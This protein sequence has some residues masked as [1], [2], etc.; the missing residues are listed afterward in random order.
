M[1]LLEPAPATAIDDQKLFQHRQSAHCES[2]VVSNLLTHHGVAM[3]EPMAFGLSSS[4]TFAY[5]PFLKMAGMPMIAYRMM[6]GSIIR[7]VEKRLKMKWERRQ[8]SNPAEGKA[9][10][11]RKIDEGR[12]VGLQTCVY[13]LPYFPEDMRFHFNMHNLVAFAREGDEYIISDPVFEDVRRCD[14]ASLEKARFAKGELEAK[15]MMYEP[16]QIPSEIDYAE[17]IPK[18]IRWNSKTMKAPVPIAGIKGIRFLGQNIRKLAKSNQRDKFLPLYLG[19]IVRMQEEIGTGGGGFRFIYASFL[20]ESSKLLN[21]AV[22]R[23]AATAMT[24][25]GD[26]WRRFALHATKMCRGRAK[27]D[28][29]ELDAIINRCAD[30]EQYAWKVMEAV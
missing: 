24:D 29:D 4:L 16:T 14:S 23:E 13:W 22:L 25:A 11:D 8:F 20:Q 17:A 19:H 9:A 27:M 28:A 5:L 6:P 26:E 2:G 18:A 1:T 3:S 12:P 21:S 10:L 30:K 15:G 7:G